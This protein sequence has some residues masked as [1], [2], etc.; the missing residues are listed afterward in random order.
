MFKSILTSS[1]MTDFRPKPLV[2]AIR[3]L[4]AGGIT[5]G[6]GASAL[7]DTT[8]LPVGT[9]ITTLTT[10]QTVTTLGQNQAVN[11]NPSNG[12]ATEVLNG[13]TLTVTPSNNAIINWNSFNI[14][15]GYTVHF[16]QTSSTSVVL[17][18]IG[19]SNASQ[20]MGTLTAN[21]EVFLVNANGFMFGAD[22]S[23]NVNSLV[24]ST[25]GISQ[26][27][28]IAGISNVFNNAY[29]SSP[30]TV[31]AN[32]AALQGSGK[33][34]LQDSLGNYVL[35]NSGSK[36]PIGITVQAG[37]QITT[38][39]NGGLILLAAPNVNN[40]GKISAAD[41][42]VILAAATD[43]VYLQDSTDTNLRGM[44]VEVGTGGTVTNS[45]S[46][47][48]TTGNASLIGFAVN[49]NGIV[50]ATTSVAL[51]GSVRLMA[52]EGIQ[53][54][55][56]T[57]VR[58]ELLGASTSRTSTQVASIAATEGMALSAVPVQA[59]VNLNSGSVT[60][61]NP[62]ASTATALQVQTQVKS[63]VEISGHNVNLLNGS[64]VQ[65]HSGNVNIVADE[66]PLGLSYGAVTPAEQGAGRIYM[67]SGSSIDV[68]GLKNVSVPVA[69]NVV[70]IKLQSNELSNSPTQRT[71]ILYGQTVSVDTRDATFSYDSS[72]N[73]IATVPIAN[74]SGSVQTMA[75]NI[76]QRSIAGGNVYFS[77]T[78]DVVVNAGSTL[79]FSGGS[80]AYQGGLV[81]TTQLISGGQDFDVSTASPDRVYSGL[82]NQPVYESGYTQG[83]AGG[84]LNI[85]SYAALL[86]G[87]LQGH[88]VNGILQRQE[89]EW[90]AASTLDINLL[91][92]NALVQQNVV[93]S[94][95]NSG[96]IL[97]ALDALP[98]LNS[99]SS[100][101][102]A[103]NLNADMI[104]HSGIRNIIISTNGS[105]TVD[106]GTQIDLPAAGQFNV[107]ASSFNVLG[108]ISIPS[109]AVSLG[110]VASGLANS[111]STGEINLGSSA[112]IDVSGVWVNDWL[113]N[114]QGQSLSPVDSNAGSVKLAV[115]GG[116]L[117][118]QTGSQILADG[119]AWKA[120]NGS[121]TAGSAGSISLDASSQGSG[122]KLAGSLDAWGLQKDG[123]LTVKANQVLIGSTTTSTATELVLSPDFFQQ[124]SFSSYNLV[125]SVYGL[126]VA[127][128]V[129]LDLVQKNPQ[130]N[131]ASSLAITGSHLNNITQTPLA[132]PS[133]S[134]KA[135]SLTLSY[136]GPYY[137]QGVEQALSIG[138]G[139]LIQTDPG[140]TVTL[141]SDTSI[142]VDGVINTPAG[143][144][145]LN[146]A[147]PTYITTDLGYVASQGIWLGANSQLLARGSFTPQA[148]TIGLVTGNVLAGG[149]VALTANRGYI[150]TEFGSNIDVSGISAQ[151]QAIQS[152]NSGIV[153]VTQQTPSSA[154][155]IK[156]IAGQGIVADGSF[157]AL[158]GGA[159][160]A[161]GS[162]S[163]ELNSNLLNQPNIFNGTQT[164]FP[165]LASTIQITT[166][167]ASVGLIE[168]TNV[169]VAYADQAMLKNNA[170]NTAGFGSISL[171]TDAQLTGGLLASAILFN[172]NV[173]ME[174]SRQIILDAPNLETAGVNAQINLAAPYLAIG[175][176]QVNQKS[177]GYAL[178]ATAVT[179]SGQFT[180][181]NAEG[182][183]L[184]GGVSFSGFDQVNLTSSGDVRMIGDIDANFTTK[185]YLGELNLAGNL[186]IAAQRVYPATLTGYAF[187]VS[188]T[189]TFQSSGSNSGGILS[190]G[191]SLT[192]NANNIVQAGD[193]AAPFGAIALNAVQ[194]L[195]LADGGITSVSGGAGNVVP[196]GVGTS[197]SWLYPLNSS[198]L[199]NIVVY[200][201]TTNN[202]PQK[203][204]SLNGATVNTETGATINLS[205]GGDLYAYE[206]VSGT[207]GTTDVLNSSQQF[208]VIPGVNNILTPYDP[209][210]Y[211][212]SGLTMGESV[213]LH[214]A[215]GLAAGWYTLLPAHYALLPG[216]YLITPESGTSGQYQ[217]T[218]NAAGDA[219]VSGYYGVAGTSI[220]NAVTQGFEVQSGSIFTGSL[221]QTVSVSKTSTGSVDVYTNTV[222]TDS[223]TPSQ[224]NAYLAS[225]YIATLAKQYGNVTPQLPQD[226][227]SMLV[228]AV[229]QLILDATLVATTTGTGLGGQVDISGNNLEVVGSSADLS[230]LP[231][232][233]VGLLASQL[234]SFNAP[235][236]LLGGKR[237]LTASGELLTITAS[238][239]T[240]SGDV[241]NDVSG[242]NNALTGTEILLAAS[243]Q[244]TV[245]TGAQVMSNASSS[246]VAGGTLILENS[247]GGSDGALLRVSA[248]GQ[249]TVE[250][251]LPI[252]G[253]GGLLDIGTGA[254]LTASGSMLLD[255]SQNTVSNGV[256]NI[257]GGDLALN[258]S[259]ISIG[260]APAGTSGLVLSQLPTDI[261]QLSFNSTGDFDLYG[262]AT[263]NSGN[264]S[265][266]AAAINGFANAGQTAT[267]TA[268][269]QL[270]LAN[271]GAS[272]AHSGTSTGN[273]V[274]NA[275]NIILGSG[276]YA[277]N[278]FQN[279]QFNA[280]QAIDGI[281]AKVAA[282]TSS[283]VTNGSV[284]NTNSSMPGVL[285]VGGDITLNAEHFSGGNGATT[286]INA[287]NHQVT[288]GS[289][290]ADSSPSTALGVSWTV[291]GGSISSNASFDLK[292]GILNL[293]ATNGDIDLNSG[294]SINLSGAAV[295]YNG[296]NEY[297]AAGS[298]SL[299]SDL[300]NVNL[301]SGASVNLAGYVASNKEQYSNA[302]SLTVQATNGQFNWN[303]SID[304]TG[305]AVSRASGVTTGNAQ[306]NVANFGAG[307][308]SALNTSLAAAGFSNDLILTQQ[309]G[310]INIAAT[311]VVTA[312]LLQ[313]SAEQ[314]AVNVVGE[315][316]VSGASA[317][318]VSIYGENGIS[319]AS[320]GK[321]YAMATA[322][323][324]AG[325]G[326]T[327]DTV[328][329]TD[330]GSGLLDLS[331]VGGVINVAAGSGGSGG[332]VLLRTGRNDA[333]D[334]VNVTTINTR[335]SGVGSLGTVLEATQVYRDINAG[336]SN[337]NIIT[338]ANI[339]TWKADTATF[340][341]NAPQITNNSGSALVLM[342]GIE[343][344][345]SGNLT[346]AATLDFMSGGSGWN[347]T[348]STWSSGW[349]YGAESLPG[350]LT[351][352]AGG[353]LNID[354]SISDGVAATP[355]VG[356]T[357][358]YQQMIQPGLSWSYDLVAGGNVNLAA[359]Y[360]AANPLSTRNVV[361]TQVVVRTGTGS[362]NIQAGK[363]IE[364]NIDTSGVLNATDNA[365][366]V[367]TVGTTALYNTTQ[368][369]AGTIPGIPAEQSGESL[370][371]Y[372]ASLTQSQLNQV[373]RYG[374]LTES[375]VGSTYLLAEYPT[376]GG[377]VSLQA[378]GNI[379]GQQTGG[380][381]AD[382]LVTP[383]SSS[384]AGSYAAA[385]WGINISGGANSTSAS[386]HN[387]NQN[388]GALGGGNITVRAGGNVNDLSV[389]IPTTGKPLG[390][391]ASYGKHNA[392]T[393]NESSTYINGGGN[394][395]LTAGNDIVAGEYYVGLGTAS[396]Q[397][398]GSISEDDNNPTSTNIGMILD[399]GSA[400]FNVQAR[401]DL[402]LE[403]AMNP[404]ALL[405]AGQATG[406]AFFTYDAN[407]ALNL[408]SVGGN[409][410]L[411]ND[412]TSIQTLKNQNVV[413]SGGDPG[414]VFTVYPGSVSAM[415]LSGDIRIDN[416]MAL[417]PALNGSLQL[418]ANGNIGI[419]PAAAML[420]AKVGLNISANLI[421][422]SDVNPDVL[423]G[424][425][426]PASTLNN[427]VIS[428]Y[429][430]SANAASGGGLAASLQVPSGSQKAALIVAK[431]GNIAFPNALQAS[432]NLPTAADIIAGGNISDLTIAA[433][434][435]VA[436]DITLIQAGGNINF[437]TTLDDNGIVQAS[438]NLAGITVAGPGV[439]QVLAGG[440]VNLG[441]SLGIDTIGNQANVALS[442]T[443]ASIEIL[444]GLFNQSNKDSLDPVNQPDYEGFISSYDTNSL[445]KSELTGL[446]ANS[447]SLPVLLKVLFNEIQ[448]ST[449]AAAA[450]PASQRYSLY[451]QGFAA[452]KALFPAA[453]Y[454]GDINMVFSQIATRAGG[455][456]SLL[457]PGGG[458][459]VGLAGDQ[460][461]NQKGASQLG[462][463]VQQL[464]NLNMFTQ[465]DIN[466]NQ[467]R[468]FTEGAGD[469]TAW[470]S[471]GS[472]DAGKGA[473]SAI[474][475]SQ[476][477]TVINS[478]GEMTT[479]FPPVIAG[480]GIQA[481]GGGNV[482]LA[483]PYG[484][485]NAG[486][487]G[488][489]GR[490][491][492]IAAAAT[493]G[494]S[495]ISST[496]TTVGVPTAVAPPV[497]LAGADSAAAGAS[498]AGAQTTTTDDSNDSDQANGKQKSSVAILTTDLVGFGHCSVGDV[499]N[500]AKGCGG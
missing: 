346:L 452:I 325:G 161:G 142:F 203:G 489:S 114:L 242:K 100:S 174:A 216:A 463:L 493:Q 62:A 127:D 447:A 99:N 210:Q 146:I 194:T 320:T 221:S 293:T 178:A 418:L 395:Q 295:S 352:R 97:G 474:S 363:N 268:S 166:S 227:G 2:I 254:A 257:S 428:D 401:Q 423:P 458:V 153:D 76:D 422:M 84:S 372:L 197:S 205:G 499:K 86:D 402:V 487:A 69:D 278:G 40:Q 276:Q 51:N 94:N 286:T 164:V 482:Y 167:N 342:P 344:Q 128:N 262:A 11:L 453:T 38:N 287:G 71:G 140:G 427:S 435:Q 376:D 481:I 16:D 26:A 440:S 214:A 382:W 144:I 48:A 175:S 477:V 44:L 169:P 259:R 258:S 388:V 467:S 434:N 291:S 468:V 415:A 162:L 500:A 34:Y 475:A 399:V 7:A 443:G 109:G 336:S 356:A 225:N 158:P 419:D 211:A 192:V 25:L 96:L 450:A 103:L 245:A 407:S 105:L 135:D 12:T 451:Q 240:V 332:S 37:A 233:I 134:R 208:A 88:T 297:A 405:A 478:G 182:I 190:A 87:N 89:G 95:A 120:I 45:G 273:L 285:T 298:L 200:D 385:I 122:I 397:A 118:L 52:E 303:G 50:S 78:G 13:H 252:N 46:I 115:A 83:A 431:N 333:T 27:D 220:A 3:L 155:A 123:S 28:L 366:A 74:I 412:A 448:L 212:G 90:A 21:G 64:L 31:V 81:S 133:Y 272:S 483:A 373:L 130:L 108:D 176:S 364:F 339:A 57:P 181:S 406:E 486:E 355:I 30:S 143:N 436:S 107:T 471:K 263:F 36:I 24:A 204:L 72:G 199:N 191:G 55:S 466:V 22:S 207:G 59:T 350:F 235:S 424:V 444:A 112:S 266:S 340:M 437:D 337:A 101:P 321:I 60:S 219:I 230:A 404:T 42:Q 236:L 92:G 67:A 165:D 282:T 417:F 195:T 75:S 327:L 383:S 170:L 150:V 218:Y 201:Q 56:T 271:N 228:D 354:A 400:A 484:V 54:P 23:V 306:L 241:N 328:H 408:Q 430:V 65:A 462:I 80:I 442:D 367:Y 473:K 274:L 384:N 432:I 370:Q 196:F 334:S 136:T 378:G 311:D 305:G 275:Q 410:V 277:I 124:G 319:L 310:D 455:D 198:G 157:T 387:F 237:S 312:S 270:E 267:I 9:D 126:K 289:S 116:D 269:N 445:Y 4:I 485:V 63:L 357:A 343:V 433:Q 317:G 49:Q 396:L 131:A 154:G 386:N 234:N 168:G 145:A 238:N 368:L 261:K 411:L 253:S 374:L 338:A 185:N 284:G 186:D 459:N 246:G 93:F 149:T 441:S 308:F 324:N 160:V 85:T 129:Q 255:S 351:L 61:V 283:S 20:I 202:L 379:Q 371:T 53:A 111:G 193:L 151:V 429:L 426:N 248:A 414:Y 58:G 256:L 329:H 249:V 456:I 32:G 393:W 480:S 91:N 495:N 159:G 359:S 288:L 43:K 138:S 110:V 239:V 244:V 265:I 224:F 439:L 392:I 5:V 425:T 183:D 348:T 70:S 189:A 403:T 309:S 139:T 177:Q 17:N 152:G 318:T 323:G 35:D 496:G 8:H 163:V 470:S 79:N 15:K 488:I 315:I 206:F 294:S 213:Y 494:V 10:N 102:V 476:P 375:A 119:G 358:K 171:Q 326:V 280:S 304:A 380:Q 322:A 141:N 137:Q 347:A 147:L 226:A 73:L 454:S 6:A 121:V 330:T 209:Q 29:S 421:T 41:G 331:A 365:S 498:K 184:I 460:S 360:M 479:T 299:L 461:G 47:M 98:V 113:D 68:S 250:R 106:A 229:N 18:N 104:S 179:G 19:D 39:A 279:I 389:M 125:S 394:L 335:V 362:I 132:L 222:N 381:I 296:T 247:N 187:N 341:N 391:V 148:S 281:G 345:S 232:G 33:S 449:A 188:D 14:D 251:D 290:G 349:R 313:L 469:I 1:P 416:S 361:D 465:G 117:L 77:S 260:D 172:G 66:T 353:D 491:I 413:G 243:N 472:I 173:Q 438:T 409:V 217:T 497:G 180:T 82:F 492:A 302:G 446:S 490:D 369:L 292:S 156:L 464:G 307:G 314:G 398:G 215:D 420:I 301:V 264:V 316:N 390:V 457:T 300:G 231:S 223:A 377:N